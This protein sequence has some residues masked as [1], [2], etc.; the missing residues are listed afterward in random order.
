MPSKKQRAK[1]SKANRSNSRRVPAKDLG[2]DKNYIKKLTE[3]AGS[4]G[5]YQYYYNGTPSP[6]VLNP[7][8]HRDM[9][10]MVKDYPD[11]PD[12]YI[13][14]LKEWESNWVRRAGGAGKP[15]KEGNATKEEQIHYVL[16]I[17]WLVE[18]GYME[19]D[20]MNGYLQMGTEMSNL[21]DMIIRC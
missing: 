20:N 10:E 17:I 5:V 18:N 4:G 9:V 15:L 3:L 13:G 6:M 16:N 2:D 21:F 8:Q 12:H 7:E 14:Q 1:A 19:N 11:D